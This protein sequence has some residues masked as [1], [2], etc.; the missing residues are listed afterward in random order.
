MRFRRRFAD[1][2]ERQLDAFAEDH[3]ALLERIAEART[4]YAAAGRED[5]E[6]RF[7]AYQAWV[8][9][10]TDV[11]MQLR[12]NYA[13]TLDADAADEYELAFNRAVLRRFGDLAF[14]LEQEDD[15]V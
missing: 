5:A 8:A 15:D 11:L 7:G 13:S 9:D 2:V 3:A 12:E 6:D 14:E 10:G 1:V 4:A